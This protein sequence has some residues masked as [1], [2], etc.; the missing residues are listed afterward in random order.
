MNASAEHNH[1]FSPLEGEDTDHSSHISFMGAPFVPVDSDDLSSNKAPYVFIGAPFDEGNVGKPGCED[2]AREFR[3]ASLGIPSYWF[4]FNVDLKGEVVDAGDVSMPRVNPDVARERIYN[5]VRKVLAAGKIPI[6]CGGD[7]SISIPAAK[8]LSDHLGVGKKM[9][10]MH[11]GAH[12]DMADNWAGETHLSTNAMARITELRNLD[13]A[14]CAHI[15]AR[16]SSNLKD[17]V[18]LAKHRGLR[19]YP[20]YEALDRGIDDVMDDAVA[21]VWGGTDAQYLSLNLNILDSS[22][23]PGVTA[24]ETGGLESRELMRIAKKISDCGHISVIDVTELCPMSDVSESTCRTAVAVV[25]R[26][27]AGIQK[28]HGKTLD[29][30]LRRPGWKF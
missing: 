17:H 4:E 27:M 9:G 6:I 16:N 26:I 29:A 19:F 13:M 20:M 28:V 11:L 1:L 25:L 3:V 5:A 10:Y 30:S 18:D 22:A 21:R 12:L 15:G 8:A 24:T 7:R 14:N 23:A 2:G